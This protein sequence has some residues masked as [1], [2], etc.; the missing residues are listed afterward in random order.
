MPVDCICLECGGDFRVPP[1]RIKKG[2]GKFCS[3]D[4][5][6]SYQR[7]TMANEPNCVC[8]EC[9]EEFYVKPSALQNG[10][11]HYCSRDCKH[12]AMRIGEYRNCECCGQQFYVSQ[13]NLKRGQDKYCSPECFR[14]HR[15]ENSYVD[16]TCEYCG[17]TFSALRSRIVRGDSRFCSEECMREGRKT[18]ETVNCRYCGKEFYV[19]KSIVEQSNRGLYCSADCHYK[20]VRS[21]EYIKCAY[22]GR[23]FYVQPSGIANGKKY[24]SKECYDEDR[25]NL[26]DTSNSGSRNQHRVAV[27][28]KAVFERDDYTCQECGQYGYTLHA[29][30]LKDWANHPDLRFEVSNGITLCA[31]CHKEIY[32]PWMCISDAEIPE[33]VREYV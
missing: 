21:G 10:A 13:A 4:C 9:G 18:G 16:T 31:R 25:R 32:H 30:H 12:K 33:P 7:R 14:Q 26:E 19:I 3:L 27:W 29:H 28:R 22:C 15:S 8:E 20:D 5:Y 2:G 11:G 6:H 17:K 1:S 23:E 24:C